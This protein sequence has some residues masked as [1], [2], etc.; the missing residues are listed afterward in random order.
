MKG[1]VIR[2]IGVVIGFL[3]LVMVRAGEETLFYDPLNRFFHSDF[4]GQPL[5]D[6]AVGQYLLSLTLRFVIN[7]LISLG[8]IYVFL[9]SRK[10]LRVA[11]ILYGAL[12]L[13]L[14]TALTIL[15]LSQTQQLMMLFYIRRLLMHPL[16]LFIFLPALY[17]Q[18]KRDNE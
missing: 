7:T 6:F 4:K 2:S 5:P 8:I 18:M 17:F 14:I 9:W 12:F 16:L 13:L 15:L 1:T 3:L 10:Y 11:A